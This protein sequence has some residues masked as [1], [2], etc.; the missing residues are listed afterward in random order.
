MTKVGVTPELYSRRW[1]LNVDYT[2]G[3]FSYQFGGRCYLLIVAL[4]RTADMTFSTLMLRRGISGSNL[5]EN[6][7]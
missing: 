2:T 5:S 7:Y 4:K 6:I 1:L 3:L